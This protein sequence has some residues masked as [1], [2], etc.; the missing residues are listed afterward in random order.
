MISGGDAAPRSLRMLRHIASQGAPR[1][2]PAPPAVGGNDIGAVEAAT[3][4]ASRIEAHFFLTFHA[5]IERHRPPHGRHRPWR[6]DGGGPA[7]PIG[8]SRH[9]PAAAAATV[10]VKYR[11]Y[12]LPRVPT[13][14][15]TFL[16]PASIGG[17]GGAPSRQRCRSGVYRRLVD[18]GCVVHLSGQPQR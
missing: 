11:A 9:T 2:F 15:L 1:E 14:K 12:K 5:G 18:R 7:H 8:R 17:H 3:V 10:P 16:E 6:A 4:S 13:I